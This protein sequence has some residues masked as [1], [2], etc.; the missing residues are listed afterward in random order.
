[1]A[2]LKQFTYSG[3]VLWD[4]STYAVTRCYSSKI[5]HQM[6]LRSQTNTKD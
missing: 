6:Q 5:V 3:L 2:R 4:L 1:V